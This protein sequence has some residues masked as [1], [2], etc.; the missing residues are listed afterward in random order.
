MCVPDAACCLRRRLLALYAACAASLTHIKISAPLS[1]VAPRLYTA[2]QDT[3]TQL[4]SSQIQDLTALARS[5]VR[6]L[7]PQ[8]RDGAVRE[9]RMQAA[10]PLSGCL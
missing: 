8:V 3:L 9:H 10:D 2:M 5:M 7:D 6:E 1:P 4:Y